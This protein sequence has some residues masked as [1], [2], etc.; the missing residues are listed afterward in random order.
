MFRFLLS[1][2]LAVA[3]ALVSSAASAIPPDPVPSLDLRGYR[4][5]TDPSSSLFLEAA[6]TPAHGDWNLGV[7][8]SYV[9]RP[10]VLRDEKT[11]DHVFSVISHQLTGDLVAN[12]GALGRLSF[13]ADLPFAMYQTGDAPT[14][15]SI[16]TLGPTSIKAQALGDLAFTGKLLI[17][18][19]TAG[20][21]GGFALALHE[22]FT[23]PTGDRDSFL[24]EG[25][26][27]STTRFLAEYR[28]F[29]LALQAAVG[30]KLRAETERF[31]CALHP[32]P[33][34]GR[35]DLCATRIGHE[36]PFAFGVSFRPQALGIDP[37]G[38]FTVFLETQ[39][40]IPIYPASPFAWT[41]PAALEVGLGGRVALG[42]FS[43]V[44]GASTGFFGIGTGPLRAMLSVGWAPRIRDV[45][46]DGV[47]DE[48][49]QCREIPEDKDGFEDQDGCPDGD[50][51]DDGVPDN[52]DRCPKQKEDEDGIADDDGC[53]EAAWGT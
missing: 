5:S 16:A 43:I 45:D 46:Q 38:R 17:V 20:D 25:A 49:D 39:G 41:D 9:H 14:Y 33:P 36:L 4:P 50:N 29:V 31:A 47:P 15:D 32:Q 23:A 51:D 13:G 24:G 26:I 11:F 2:P 53:P 28:L 7:A 19:P 37:A 48:E 52:E 6:S 44:A 1:L 40:H 34:Q 21:M 12:I 30:V 10:V 8:F 22:R 42:D 3:A 35:E 18:A 27:T